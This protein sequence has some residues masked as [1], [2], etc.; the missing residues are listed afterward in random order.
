MFLQNDRYLLLTA[1]LYDAK[2]MATAS[3]AKKDKMGQ[4]AAQDR[5]RVIQQGLFCFLGCLF[6]ICDIRKG[7]YEFTFFIVYYVEMKTL[8]C[9]P[10][11]NSAIKVKDTPK[12]EKKAAVVTD[13]KEELNFNLFEQA[14]APPAEKSQKCFDLFV[15]YILMY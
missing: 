4:R 2:E 9:H 13:G 10:V 6:I 3:K 15:G 14:E 7:Q 8:E 5:I 1:Q 11:F 12:E